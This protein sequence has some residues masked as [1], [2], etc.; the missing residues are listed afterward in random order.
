MIVDYF[1]I[2]KQQRDLVSLYL[3]GGK[4]AD[5]NVQ[6]MIAFV[7][8]V[9]LT[10]FTLMTGYIDWFYNYGWFTGSFM[11]AAIYYFLKAKQ[12]PNIG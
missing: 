3:R 1:V 6:G 2:N 8:P 7:V 11:G 9:A 5:V 10:L 4:Y 12:H